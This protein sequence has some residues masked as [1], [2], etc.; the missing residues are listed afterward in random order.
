MTFPTYPPAPQ[1]VGARA[2]YQQAL[3]HFGLI[4]AEVH[5]V[6]GGDAYTVVLDTEDDGRKHLW[7]IEGLKSFDE[8]LPLWIGDCLHNFRSAWDH[9]AY[10]LIKATGHTPTKQTIFPFLAQEQAKP[11]YI[12]PKPGPHVEAMQIVEEVQPYNVGQES[13]SLAILDNLDI[14]DKHRE[15]LAVAAG[16]RVPYYGS[17]EGVN[18]I[19]NWA[20]GD[21]VV[22][23][24]VVMWAIID[25]PQPKGALDGNVVLTTKLAPDSMPVPLSSGPSLEQLIQDIAGQ[26]HYRLAQFDWFFDTH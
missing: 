6:T 2:K 25:P 7:R 24:D 22:D 15:L 21:V 26:L 10:E 4:R 13:N 18:T 11:V 1:L 12:L 20:T 23:G 3:V 19:K 5:R 16:I 14:V 9:I 8:G 17:P